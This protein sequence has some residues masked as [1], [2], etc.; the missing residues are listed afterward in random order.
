M[1]LIAK[2][3][4]SSALPQLDKEFDYLI[5]ADL[6][7]K[8]AVGYLVQV[9]FGSGGKE[10]I[11][12]VCSIVDELNTREKLLSISAISS[13]ISVLS[14]QQLALCQAVAARQAGTVGE[15]L[16]NAIP[17]RFIRI[18]KSFT[19]EEKVA[20]A[21][22][23]QILSS[24]LLKHL[25]AN[26]R[27]YFMPELLGTYKN[28]GWADEFA[29]AALN[30]YHLGNSSLVVLPDFAELERF[31]RSLLRLGITHLAHR[32]SSADTG[33]QRHL[34][35]LFASS[36]IG[37][38]YGLR[39][40]SF[41]PAKNLGLIMIWDDGD[42]S[43]IEQSSPYWHSREVLLQRA[44]LEGTKIVLASHAP[45]TEV[46]RLIKIG[47]LTPISTSSEKP[48][49]RITE[50]NDRLDADSFALISNAL[51]AGKSVL[52]QIAN[53]GWASSLVCVSCKELRVCTTCSSSIWIDPSGSFRCRSCKTTMR[54]D[55][56]SCGR[57]ATRPTVLGASAI[58]QQMERSF[59]GYSVV[60]SNGENRLTT[61][62]GE[63]LLVVSTPGAEPEVQGGYSVILIA[64]AARMVGAP[65][66]RALEQS[67][68]RWANAISLATSN[69]E[70]IFVGLKDSLAT[71]MRDL[72]FFAAVEDDYAD[73]VELAL[74]PQTRIASIVS[75]NPDD[76]KRLITELEPL[77]RSSKL[78]E[79]TV[80]QANTLVLDYPYSFGLELAATL[81]NA[82]QKLTRSSKA[83]K[84]GERVYRIN[85][86]DSKVI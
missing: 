35:H 18:E 59:P 53:A 30:E 11:G 74:P 27:T 40:A 77:L 1:P 23:E 73:R 83:K 33:S 28:T 57:T 9:P 29:L 52:V 36:S 31:E 75:S 54:L 14:P 80:E 22:S 41:A 64:D 44:E 10:K 34:N 43:H 72:D 48:S 50:L 37:I 47:H 60:H 25:A 7:E 38:N 17:K 55:V 82:A 79:L 20:P 69:A 70:V 21:H 12:V 46:V 45:S 51:K 84:P 49:T 4:F 67:L 78:R 2:V 8:L 63:S 15:L 6:Q 42:E 19:L 26:P 24:A 61:L 3:R 56:C 32:H 68:S 76:H 5:P 86:D 13:I 65:R 81:S 71:R 16:S 39:G 58:A 62:V 85:M 66:L